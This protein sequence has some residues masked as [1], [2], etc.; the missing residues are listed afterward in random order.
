MNERRINSR[1]RSFLQGRIYFNQ[2]RSSLDCLV[3][4]L[5]EDGAK[6]KVSNSVALP[7]FVELHIPN[8]NATYPA[9]VQW[10]AGDEIG[11]AF[12]LENESPSIV[13]EAPAVDLAG[14]VHQL[15]TDMAA[16]QRKFNELREEL[17]KR[18]SSAI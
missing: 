18:R 6:L 15:E 1:L 3:R 11:V 4:D 9:K 17:S 5:S 13:P 10:R 12:N 14:R 16:L 2:R 8:K 7:E